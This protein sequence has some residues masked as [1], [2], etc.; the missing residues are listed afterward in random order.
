MLSNSSVACRKKHRQGRAARCK[1][2]DRGAH[3]SGLDK[4]EGVEDLG[5]TVPF[6][7]YKG[8]TEDRSH[9]RADRMKMVKGT[10]GQCDGRFG[11]CGCCEVTNKFILMADLAMK[12]ESPDEPNGF[13]ARSIEW[14]SYFKGLQNHPAGDI[15]VRSCAPY[16]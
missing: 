14:V 15:T 5:S 10:L 12:I 8:K 7:F 6:F 4:A 2:E 1:N 11:L 13:R 9:G 3:S 16:D